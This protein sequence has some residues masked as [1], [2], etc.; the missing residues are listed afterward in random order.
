VKRENTV[1]Q[2]AVTIIPP[3]TYAEMPHYLSS[4]DLGIVA[5]LPGASKKFISNIKVGEFLCAGLPYLICRGIS[6][7]DS[8]AEASN[9]GIVSEDLSEEAIVKVIPKIRAL[10]LEPKEVIAARCREAGIHYR[11][12]ENQY[13]QYKLAVDALTN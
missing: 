13:A 5:V 8:I 2:V 3:V 11:G 1:F 4:A 6:E 7:D 10:L 12:F 9:A